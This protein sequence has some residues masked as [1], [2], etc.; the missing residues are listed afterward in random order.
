MSAANQ[1]I[2]KI[3]G[4]WED[5]TSSNEFIIHSELQLVLESTGKYESGIAFSSET[6]LRIAI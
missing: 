4:F 1:S 3:H 6:H 5:P 2:R